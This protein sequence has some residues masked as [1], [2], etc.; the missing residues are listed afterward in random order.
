[1]KKP[2]QAKLGKGSK[3]L[4]LKET[5]RT[6]DRPQEAQFRADPMKQPLQKEPWIEGQNPQDET[7]RILGQFR[8]LLAEYII[9]AREGNRDLI[10]ELPFYAQQLVEALEELAPK[11]PELFA[12]QAQYAVEWPI[13]AA[14]HYPKESDFKAVADLIQL[15]SKAVVN[16]SPRARY[17]LNT[18]INRFLLTLLAGSISTA[19]QFYFVQLPKDPPKLTAKTLPYYLDEFIMPMLD[20][21]R[22]TEGSWNGIPAVASIVKRISY[23]SEHRSAVRNRIKRALEAMA[24]TKR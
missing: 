16:V 17:K 2:S 8:V 11:F 10:T 14:R 18:R 21:I 3:T 24:A 7:R 6:V 23:E 9:L 13:M 4:S 15:G 5:P 1:M 20:E 19:K 22:E 12:E